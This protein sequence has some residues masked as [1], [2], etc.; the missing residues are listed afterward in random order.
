MGGVLSTIYA[1]L[2]ADG[3]LK[4]LVCFTTP[5]D[6]Q[7]D[8]A[9]PDHGPTS[10]TSMSTG[11]STPLGNVPP[12]LIIGAFDML[13]PAGRLAGQVRLWDNMWN[14]DY[15]KCY[16]MMDRWAAETLPLA[17]EYFRQIVKELLRKNALH[18][19]TLQIG[20]R[21]GRPASASSVPLLHVIAQHDH[22]VPPACAAPLVAARAVRATR[23]K[24]MLPGGHVSLVA[25][26]EC[27]QAHVAHTRPMAWRSDRHE[28]T[29]PRTL[30]RT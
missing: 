1:A 21:H 25:G 19:G 27:R 3:P 24:L 22:I 6:F 20:G 26:A 9:V 7:A 29:T 14:D 15:V 13:R 16:R 5:I 28:R 23:K 10:A 2:H 11:W 17:G 30:P 18:E 12:E 8:D 4:N